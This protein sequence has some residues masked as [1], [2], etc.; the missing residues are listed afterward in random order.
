M[1]QE[2]NHIFHLS[3]VVITLIIL[4]TSVRAL[5]QDNLFHRFENE[6]G[7]S[8]VYISPAMF[9]LM[10]KMN[11]GKRNI[12]SIASKLTHLQILE[13]ERPS[14]FA[15]I[16]KTA[17]DYYVKNKYEVVMTVK[18][19]DDHVVIYLKPLGKGQNEFVLI[20]EEKAELSI[21]NIVGAISL[22]DI[23]ELEK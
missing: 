8:T 9:K 14:L 21:I 5:G 3:R 19:E 20:S 23:K 7:V 17:T 4:L 1:Q 10:P 6:K 13:C 18:D 12:S 2:T 22:N 11:T 15:D 16:K